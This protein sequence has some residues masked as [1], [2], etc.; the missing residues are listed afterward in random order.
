MPS[1]KSKKPNIRMFLRWK[2]ITNSW[3]NVS[4]RFTIT[5]WKPKEAKK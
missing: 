3:V 5:Y 2:T 1:R 4:K